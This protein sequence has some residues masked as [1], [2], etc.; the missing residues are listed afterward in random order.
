MGYSMKFYKKSLILFLILIVSIGMVSACEIDDGSTAVFNDVEA[1]SIAEA[2]LV[3]IDQEETALSIDQGDE[4]PLSDDE[5]TPITKTLNGG[6]F[7]DIQSSIDELNDGDTLELN[8]TFK[9]NGEVIN[10]TKSIT[11]KSAAKA[12]LDGNK[13]S[14]IF[15][16][17]G[18]NITLIG[19]NIINSNDDTTSA[20]EG[21]YEGS[22]NAKYSFL[23]CNFEK[24]VGEYGG[25][26]IFTGATVLLD[27]TGCT[28]K[29]NKAGDGAAIYSCSKNAVIR[30]CS[31]IGNNAGTGGAIYSCAS[32]L[33][34]V[35]SIFK[36]NT[37]TDGGCIYSE[38]SLSIKDSSFSN[39]NADYGGAIFSTASLSIVNSKFIK[40][41][42]SDGGAIKTSAPLTVSKSHFENNTA[43]ILGGAI[44]S[45]V[46]MTITDSKFLSNK[47]SSVIVSKGKIT[48]KN[49][50][51]AKNRSTIINGPSYVANSKFY[52]N[53]A[54]SIQGK[55]Y[56][57]NSVFKFN[58]GG[59]T[60]D[61]SGR[62]TIKK[63]SFFANTASFGAAIKGNCIVSYSNFTKNNATSKKSRGGAIEA[64][65][66]VK[67]NNCRFVSNV[68]KYM[69]GAIGGHK[70]ETITKCTF[71]NNR[72][73]SGGAIVSDN[74]VVK[75][76]TFKNN[77]GGAI[78]AEKL[79]A[80]KCTF[81]KNKDSEQ[82]GAI[83]VYSGT[84]R[85]CAFTKNYAKKTGGAIYVEKKCYVYN[86]KFTRNSV[87]RYGSAIVLYFKSVVKV[88]NC[89]FTK[90]SI[91]K[92][93][94]PFGWPFKTYGK[95]AVACVGSG[96][97]FTAVKCKG[98]SMVV[99]KYST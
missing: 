90:N 10:V 63:C 74:L 15:S 61:S 33:S 99:K 76:C 78:N 84:I 37:G 19:L 26:C 69:G 92:G 73:I 86:S 60:I 71:L 49:S 34:I 35:N 65:G 17:S 89:R 96:P 58:K 29:N 38:Y 45:S 87:Q 98:L 55:T 48:V 18:Q 32:G 70:K 30:N 7:S 27:V 24:N 5:T 31:F 47:G 36:S 16:L 64:Y 67:I 56:V 25:S 53:L 46:K 62:S 50:Y 80:S 2:D 57:I 85:N 95:G 66:V 3:S 59:S 51:F 43:S 75:D 83:Q 72:A 8:G 21:F 40:N 77:N 79:T 12:T 54:T 82:A 9:S 91:G 39:N 97:K 44:H 41:K 11:I 28:F 42:A 88:N 81:T 4:T 94:N 20:V 13:S 14:A 52:N 68:A 93:K 22:G 23:N 1:D 6:S